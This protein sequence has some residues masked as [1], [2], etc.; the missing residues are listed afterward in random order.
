MGSR[1]VFR[2]GVTNRTTDSGEERLE[3]EGGRGRGGLSYLFR[4]IR[5]ASKESV[6][7]SVSGG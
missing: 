3:M 5:T 4:W 2:K 7:V 1:R 6:S